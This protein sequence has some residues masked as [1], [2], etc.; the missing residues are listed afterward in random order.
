MHIW[1]VDNNLV[2]MNGTDDQAKTEVEV[3]QFLKEDARENSVVNE[4]AKILYLLKEYIL[5]KPVFIKRT[6]PPVQCNIDIADDKDTYKVFVQGFNDVGENLNLYLT[7]KRHMELVCKVIEKKDN[8]YYVH[9]SEAIIANKPRSAKRLAV[10]KHEVFGHRFYISKNKIDVNPLSFSV[11]NKVLFKDA[12]RLLSVQYP[13]IKVSDMDPASQAMET[14]I[15]KK[16]GKGIFMTSITNESEVEFPDLETLPARE[17]LGDAFTGFK[18]DLV[19]KGIKS[20]LLRPILYT[21]IKGDVFPI[22]YFELKTTD[23]NLEAQDYKNLKEQ[24]T[25]MVDRIKDANTIIINQKHKIVNISLNGALLEVADE[26]F[27]G[28]LLQRTD[29]TFDLLFKY[30]AGLRFYSRIHHVSKKADGKIL[31]GI[32]FHGVVHTEANSSKK[33]IKYLEESL[34]YLLKQ[35]AHFI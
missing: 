4:Q 15:I 2:T 1:Q 23:K 14:K 35:G 29:M 32:G 10:D 13:H 11:S 6:Y 16:H 18:T 21:N 5:G 12:E 34:N 28:Y 19:N 17:A 31:V 8:F 7:Y 26:E 27:Q 24:E 22:G 20:W 3:L 30:M 33:S 9:I 25:K